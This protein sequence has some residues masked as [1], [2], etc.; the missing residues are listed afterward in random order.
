M[1]WGSVTSLRVLFPG[2]RVSGSYVSR[3]QD[4]GPWVPVSGSQGS[5]SQSSRVLGPRVSDL[6]SWISGPRVLGPRSQGPRSQVLIVDYALHF[7]SLLLFLY[8]IFFK[9]DIMNFR[10]FPLAIIFFFFLWFLV[11]SGLNTALLNVFRGFDEIWANFIQRP[12]QNPVKHLGWS[13]LRK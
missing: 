1:W 13:I 12:I 6:G 3:S 10:R 5:K 11:T 2:S 8:F 9:S 4:P 7:T